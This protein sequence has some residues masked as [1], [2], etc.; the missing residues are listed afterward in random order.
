MLVGKVDELSLKIQ[1]ETFVIFLKSLQHLFLKNNESNILLHIKE[2]EMIAESDD[3]Y[4]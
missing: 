3:A 1:L 2:G 4:K